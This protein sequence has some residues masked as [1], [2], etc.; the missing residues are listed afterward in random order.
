MALEQT[1]DERIMTRWGL[2]RKAGR[3]HDPWID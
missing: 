3:M 2:A 1:L